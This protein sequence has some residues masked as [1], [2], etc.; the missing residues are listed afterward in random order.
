[1][2]APWVLAV[3]FAT[4]SHCVPRVLCDTWALRCMMFMFCVKAADWGM[5]ALTARFVFSPPFFQ[6]SASCL[7]VYHASCG[8]EATPLSKQHSAL[9]PSIS[10]HLPLLGQGEG[11]YKGGFTSAI[12]L[13][14]SHGG[15]GARRGCRTRGQQPDTWSPCHQRQ[16]TQFC[17]GKRKVGRSGYALAGWADSELSS[18]PPGWR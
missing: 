10:G 6:N 18:Q 17:G 8:A 12:A 15:Q 16:K 11:G 9:V 13:T 5:M 1:M 4:R 3:H 2:F 14:Q 7:H